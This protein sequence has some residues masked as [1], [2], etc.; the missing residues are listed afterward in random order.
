M[1][2]LKDMGYKP[3]YHETPVEIKTYGKSG[4]KANIVVSKDQG[5]SYGDVGFEKTKTGYKLHIDDT[6]Q[7]RFN[8]SKLKQ[9]YSEAKIKG[10][11]KGKSKYTLKNR[12]VV[13]GKIKIT[14]RVR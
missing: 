4:V 3:T 7:R 1:E 13:D 8:L 6:D 14:I 11:I 5:F 10:T 12:E 2:S 9:G